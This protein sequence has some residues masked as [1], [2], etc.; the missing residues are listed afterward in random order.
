MFHGM[1]TYAKLA[2]ERI[3]RDLEIAAYRRAQAE[4][5]PSIRQA[6]GYRIIRI[7]AR[8][9]AEPSLASIRSR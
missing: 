4:L 1:E 7:G 9:A 2:Q 6:I 5:A 8:L 3:E